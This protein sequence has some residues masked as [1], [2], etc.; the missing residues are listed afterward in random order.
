MTPISETI[1][2]RLKKANVKFLS[3]DNISQFIKEGELDLLQK[4]VEEKFEGV[5]ESLVIDTK[6]DHNTKETAHRVA[7]MFLREAFNGRYVPEPKNTEFPNYRKYDD[8]Y[9]V[10]PIHI[11]SFC[12]HH[13]LPIIGDVWIG[14]VEPEHLIGLSKFHR[15]TR[16]VMERPSIQE[17]SLVM[18]A[19][20]LEKKIK[21]KGLG[22]YMIANHTCVSVRGV[23]DKDSLMG[24]SVMRGTF[25]DNP[26]IKMEF[27]NLVNLKG[28]V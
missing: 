8:M 6:N 20:L 13:F 26:N 3:T 10:G 27:L 4:E 18:I 12:A 1:K 22:V 9:I 5:L 19:D 23:K 17:E 24:G 28:K 14:V 21:P 15:L 16:W 2:A 11:N 25:R 7:K